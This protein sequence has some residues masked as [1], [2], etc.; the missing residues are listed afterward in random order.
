MKIYPDSVPDQDELATTD[1]LLRPL[2]RTDVEL[3]YEAVIESAVLLRRW[4][5]GD[6]PTDDFTLECNLAD[7][8]MHEHEHESGLAFIYTMRDLTGSE[9]LGCVYVN[10]LN[11][12][13]GSPN[14]AELIPVAVDDR[15]A[16]VRF[17]VRQS[18]LSE[19]LDW[20]LLQLL[21]AWFNNQWTFKQVYFV[22][23][24]KDRRQKRLFS[25]AGPAHV[26]ELDVAGRS[27]P[28]VA[29]GLVLSSHEDAKL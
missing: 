8:A 2:R 18:R 9:C 1:F 10:R 7:L 26:F 19:D 20:R 17:W 13:I 15:Q 25:K 27:G 28:F 5:G 11:E 24:D 29:F 4:G 22:A 23:D 12:L 6:W 14:P 3:D 16:S 21:I